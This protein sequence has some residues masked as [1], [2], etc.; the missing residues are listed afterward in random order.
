MRFILSI[1]DD[2]IVKN[3]A[4]LKN[5]NEFIKYYAKSEINIFLFTKKD[6]SRKI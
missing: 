2:R 5:K 3:F 1:S 6:N 4:K